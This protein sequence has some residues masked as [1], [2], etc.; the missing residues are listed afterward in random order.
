MLDRAMENGM[1]Y[2]E[3]HVSVLGDEFLANLATAIELFGP[4]TF[5]LPPDEKH[6]RRVSAAL[7]DSTLVALQRLGLPEADYVSRKGKIKRA[8]SKQLATENLKLLTG[9]ENTA[10]AVKDRIALMQSV[11]R[12]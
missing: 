12:A 5:L 3:D 8:L 6:R 4:D 1:K 11:L 7:Y 9:Q 2:D 10:Q